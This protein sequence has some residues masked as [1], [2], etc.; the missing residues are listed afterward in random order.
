MVGRRGLCRVLSCVRVCCRLLSRSKGC[1]RVL[2]S[3]VTWR[4]SEGNTCIHAVHERD[5]A[6]S[7]IGEG[8]RGLA[9]GDR[10]VE[11]QG[12]RSGRKGLTV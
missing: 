2:I 10:I 1:R 11:R 8:K 7:R 12:D 9:V 6:S 4:V 5:D 3:W